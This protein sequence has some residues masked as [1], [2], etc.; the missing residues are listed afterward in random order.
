M[1]SVVID[2]PKFLNIDSDV[3]KEKIEALKKEKEVIDGVFDDFTNN[4]SNFSE[5]WSGDTGDMVNGELKK[6]IGYF[7]YRKKAL[8]DLI[9]FLQ[10]VVNSYEA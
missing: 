9:E 6:Y 5:Y 2:N 3:L 1:E 10:N 7:D 4:I 8:N